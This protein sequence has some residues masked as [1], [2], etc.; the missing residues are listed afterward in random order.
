MMRKFALVRD[1][2]RQYPNV[3]ITLPQRATSRSCGYDFRIPVEVVL[4]PGEKKLVFSDVKAYMEGDEVLKLYPRSG[5]STK[6]GVILANIVAII[7]ADY[8]DN[9]SNDGNIGLCLWNTSDQVVFLEAGERVCQGVFVKYQ[10]ID[11]DA[12]IKDDRQ[13]GFGSSGQQ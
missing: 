5:L 6:R 12:P 13:G 2:H 4:Q 3:E 11:D 9:E 1:E 10:I 7:D 8:V